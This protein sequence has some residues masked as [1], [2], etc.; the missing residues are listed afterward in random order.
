M[1]PDQDKQR[2]TTSLNVFFLGTMQIFKLIQME[3]QEDEKYSNRK[4]GLIHLFFNLEFIQFY[5][6][7]TYRNGKIEL[8]HLF[9]KL[10]Y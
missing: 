1:L 7:K 4:M 8:I 2:M 9:F 6:K 10:R 5:R 3:R